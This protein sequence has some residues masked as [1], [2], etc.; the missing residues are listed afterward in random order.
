MPEEEAREPR[1]A[2]LSPGL[3]YI[4]LPLG[5][6]SPQGSP[7][8]H[9]PHGPVA[10]DESEPEDVPSD[11]APAAHTAGDGGE[12][13]VPPPHVIPQHPAPSQTVLEAIPSL[14]H[15]E[16]TV[17][18]HQLL[19]VPI[20]F[21]FSPLANP[22]PPVVPARTPTPVAGPSSDPPTGPPS[23]RRSPVRPL[24]R[25]SRALRRTDIEFVMEP[26]ARRNFFL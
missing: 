10:G 8:A 12:A 13:P 24:R 11:P 20:P 7:A 9:S 21:Q 23:P 25:R 18:A 15:M 2:P 1:L 16:A 5:S 6:P 14:R 26:G 22:A 4:A 17:A 3:I 19:G